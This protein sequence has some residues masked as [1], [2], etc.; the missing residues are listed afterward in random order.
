LTI[1]LQ[2]FVGGKLASLGFFIYGIVLIVTII[3]A[4]GGMM[5]GIRSVSKKL[6]RGM[7]S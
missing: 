1:F 3:L 2:G 6:R 7:F 5:G 4:P